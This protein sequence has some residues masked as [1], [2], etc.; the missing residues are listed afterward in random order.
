MKPKLCLPPC[1]LADSLPGARSR[2]LADAFW[3]AALALYARPNLAS[4]CLA[5]QDGFG[6]DVMML[7][8]CCF[9][10]A[11]GRRLDRL[12]L[13]GFEAEVRLWRETVILPLRRRRRALPDTASARAERR[14]LLAA[15]IAAE[16]EEARRLARWSA[17]RPLRRV[18]VPAVAAIAN[19]KAYG[20]CRGLIGSPGRAALLRLGRLAVAGYSRPAPGRLSISPQR[21]AR[22]VSMPKRSSTRPTV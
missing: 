10:G 2:A 11:G 17:C 12:G 5:L 22:S 7:L 6:F 9:L 16:Y 3:R 14:R 1:R 4:A 13:S 15:E 20:A 18:A 19:L 8:F 21:R